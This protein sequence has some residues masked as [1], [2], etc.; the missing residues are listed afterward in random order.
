M[1]TTVADTWITSDTHFGHF[2]IIKYCNRPFRDTREMDEALIERWNAS[3][4]PEDTVYHGGDVYFGS[5]NAETILSRLNGR[6]YLI[7]GN[8]DNPRD[9]LLHKFFRKIRLWVP[10]KDQG[11]L[12]SHVPVHPDQLEFYDSGI[13]VHGHIHDRVLD[14]PRYVNVSVE[15]TDYR[16]L[17]IEEVIRHVRATGG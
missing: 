16:P 3:V 8:H 12:L 14:D 13:N 9:P 10:M 17:H 5:A 1:G 15:Q 6:K 11:L 2:N 4:K 7:L